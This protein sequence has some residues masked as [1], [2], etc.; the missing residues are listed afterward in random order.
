M[1]RLTTNRE[2]YLAVIELATTKAEAQPSLEAYLL[3]LR[4][5]GM[6]YEANDSISLDDFFSLLRDAFSIQPPPFDATW[7]NQHV[8]YTEDKGFP[9]WLATITSQIIDLH[10]M[11]ES[12]GLQ[13]EMRYFGVRSPRGSHWF[14]FDP[15]GYLE[16]AMAGSIGGWEPGDESGRS[17]VPG[18]VAVLDKDDQV[19][20]MNPEDVPRPVY[21][22]PTV[23]WELFRDMLDSG[24]HYE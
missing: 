13:N 24:Q 21:P 17:Y 23:S 11:A 10:E 9:G 15:C 12:G 14:N 3:T 2:L 1:T 16:C 8:T 6:Q 7:V 18:P 4:Q 5:L 20:T 19:V 22:L